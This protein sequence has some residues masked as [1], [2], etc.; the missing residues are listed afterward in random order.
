MDAGRKRES[1]GAKAKSLLTAIAAANVS[2]FLLQ[3]P[4]GDT[5]KAK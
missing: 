5:K 2:A 4:R 1:S 3:F